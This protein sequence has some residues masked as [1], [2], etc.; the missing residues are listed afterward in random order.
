M[1]PQVA[2]RLHRKITVRHD[3]PGTSKWNKIEHRLFS[4]ITQNWRGHPLT[5]L[6]VIINLIARTTTETGLKVHAEPDPNT[7]VTGRKVTKSELQ[8][9][10]LTR[11]TLH[12]EWNYS[13][14]PNEI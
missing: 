6:Q 12:G 11:D 10:H 1:L 3:P 13:L 7:Y 5:S 8:S 2:D 14:S 9:L 4:Q